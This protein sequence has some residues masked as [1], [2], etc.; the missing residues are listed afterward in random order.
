MTQTFNAMAVQLEERLHELE[1][2][3]SRVSAVLGTMSDGV[4]IIDTEN[5]ILLSNPAAHSIFLMG[6]DQPVNRSVFEYVH[7]HQIEKIILECRQSGEAR[8]LLLDYPGRSLT[9][10]ATATPLGAGQQG[11]TLLLFQDLT[12]LHRLETVRRGFHH[13]YF[14]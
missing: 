4:M 1:V 10:L 7:H 13:K 11:N 12:E 3:R 2:E 5:R 14:P 8:T 9:V 6:A